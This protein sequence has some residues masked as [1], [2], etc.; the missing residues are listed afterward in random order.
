MAEDILITQC[1]FLFH[2]K[3]R[4][5]RCFVFKLGGDVDVGRAGRQAFLNDAF[6]FVL[7]DFVTGSQGLYKKT[8]ALWIKI[9]N[10]SLNLSHA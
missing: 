3:I 5:D 1:L 7:C 10:R 2:G 6:D 9:K 4:I 8:N